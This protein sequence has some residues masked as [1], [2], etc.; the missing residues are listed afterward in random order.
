MTYDEFIKNILE[1][2]GRFACGDEYHERHHIIPK[3][4]GGT[5]D[6]ENLID[7]FARE[8]FEAHRL[9]ALENPE[10]DKLVYAWFMMSYVSTESMKRYQLTA[11]EYTELREK[12]SKMMSAKMAGENNPWYNK[13]LPKEVREKLSESHIGLFDGENNPM[14]GKHH[15]E[16][17]KVKMSKNRVG[18][19]KGEKS[20]WYGKEFPEEMVN[21]MRESAKAR[22]NDEARK[23][24]SERRKKYF[25]THK[26]PRAKLINQYSKDGCFIKMWRGSCEIEKEIGISASLVRRCCRKELKSAGGFLWF[27]ADDLTQPDKSKIISNTQQND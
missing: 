1:T 3:S 4:C 18:R 17:T 8:H 16:E 11:D 9:L 19:Y 23:E 14:Y 20:T 2:R 10:N 5:N 21:K 26:N 15:S 24:Q 13:H 22:W 6:K 12:Y 7:L 25:E 27:K